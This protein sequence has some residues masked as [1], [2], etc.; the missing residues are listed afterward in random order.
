MISGGRYFN[1]LFPLYLF[2]RGEDFENVKI[3]ERFRSACDEFFKCK[4]DLSEMG[5]NA[6]ACV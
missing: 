3:F 2:P 1:P 4:A 5:L 6:A